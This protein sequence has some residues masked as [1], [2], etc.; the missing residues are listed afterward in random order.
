MKAFRFRAQPALDLRR[1]EDDE[2]RRVCAV[3]EGRLLA[4]L[5]AEE[6]ARDALAGAQ[7]S[8]AA[9]DASPHEREW[10]RFWITRLRQ[11]TV[12]AAE[13]VTSGQQAQR[14]ARLRREETRKRVDALERLRDKARCA[15]DR[16][17]RAEEQRLMDAAGTARFVAQRRALAEAA[18]V[19]V[20][21]EQR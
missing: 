19:T 14:E 2:A 15:Y 1:R 12:L 16:A 4:A 20:T 6:Q 7:G 21:R 10:H 9:R 8:P 11:A 3:A 18:D 17:V 5:R 13:S